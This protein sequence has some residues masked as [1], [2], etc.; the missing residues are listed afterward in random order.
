MHKYIPR[1]DSLR[2]LQ[3]AADAGDTAAQLELG[4]RHFHGRRGAE[5]SLF[6]AEAYFRT[7]SVDQ[8]DASLQLANVLIKNYPLD[9]VGSE[10]VLCL[11]QSAMAG[12][13]L[14]KLNL[15]CLAERGWH[16]PKNHI[17]A[18]KLYKD[19]ERHDTP[20]APLAR[21]RHRVLAI[22]E[23]IAATGKQ[24]EFCDFSDLPAVLAI[25][26]E[27]QQLPAKDPRRIE[28]L[29]QAADASFAPA[30]LL[31]GNALAQRD[32][33]AAFRCYRRAADQVVDEAILALAHCHDEGIGT[34]RDG[35]AAF[36]LFSLAAQRNHFAA[37]KW[38]ANYYYDSSM[39]TERMRWADRYRQMRD[40]GQ[41]TESTVFPAA[42]WIYDELLACLSTLSGNQA[43]IS[44]P[45]H[46]E[47]GDWLEAFSINGVQFMALAD[48]VSGQSGAHNT[49]K[50]VVSQLKELLEVWPRISPRI[51]AQALEQ[52]DRTIP[53][54]QGEATLVIVAIHDGM[55]IGA[56]V[57]D[58]SAYW[59]DDDQVVDLTAAQVRRPLMGTGRTTGTA[60][61]FQPKVPGH[62]LVASDGLT[63]QVKPE[64]I[65][66]IVQSATPTMAVELLIE[67]IV[68][69][70]GELLDDTS[71]GI[72]HFDPVW[73]V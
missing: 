72:H 3:L 57:G 71:I 54:G 29:T 32:K 70:L 36:T 4:L 42:P 28:L 51:L 48:G 37:V 5:P 27:A 68:G 69:H 62:I 58:S 6:K 9:Q 21:Y 33:P 2:S 66:R 39:K 44:L 31:L 52:I 15:A 23:Q 22:R 20:L 35:Q 65:R 59:I 55:V 46:H 43:L 64:I 67:E 38:I 30:L 41:A 17:L 8:P 63:N 73:L 16:L 49:A 24:T 13:S 1:L 53:T 12:S 61:E 45:Q 26:L 19:I 60:F 11:M 40:A 10:I 50:L 47:N 56:S 18:Q 34:R 14:A 25:T 7:A